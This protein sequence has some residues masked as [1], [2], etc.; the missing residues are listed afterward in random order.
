MFAR[1]D[2][3]GCAD[4]IIQEIHHVIGYD[5]VPIGQSILGI[6]SLAARYRIWEPSYLS[7]R[8]FSLYIPGTAFLHVSVVVAGPMYK[9][10]NCPVPASERLELEQHHWILSIVYLGMT[11]WQGITNS[12]SMADNNKS[13]WPP[14]N[15]TT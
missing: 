5:M 6:V 15:K 8:G 7:H 3:S 11:G 9:H 4:Y 12:L 13:T 1:G 2:G 14:S 10:Y